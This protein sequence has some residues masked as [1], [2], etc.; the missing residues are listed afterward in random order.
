MGLVA[1]VVAEASQCFPKSVF[2]PSCF[3]PENVSSLWTEGAWPLSSPR[4]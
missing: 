4:L 3:P 2:F 1:F